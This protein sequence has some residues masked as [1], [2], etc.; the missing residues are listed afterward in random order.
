MN[1]KGFASHLMIALAAFLIVVVFGI[2]FF[3]GKKGPSP[4]PYQPEPTLSTSDTVES[5]AQ[6]LDQTQTA[7]LEQELSTLD[8][9]LQEL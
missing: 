3:S 1:M 6:D 5:I 8:K 2:V 7:D 9:D 4:L